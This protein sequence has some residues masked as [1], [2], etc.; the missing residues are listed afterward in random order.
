M[1]INLQVE[2]V[3][4]LLKEALVILTKRPEK[5]EE[6]GD[7]ISDDIIGTWLAMRWKT[8]NFTQEAYIDKMISDISDVLLYQDIVP[9]L[10]IFANKSLNEA[11]SL[12][13]NRVYVVRD[14][15]KSLMKSSYE[16]Y[17][18]NN[19]DE[20][21]EL[22]NEGM[23]IVKDLLDCEYKPARR[24]LVELVFAVPSLRKASDNEECH[25]RWHSNIVYTVF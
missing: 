16:F 8:A 15:I 19:F 20:Y 18:I 5:V 14:F 17:G 6:F 22:F 25:I 1:I 13:A 7:M 12:V 3:K 2:E 10:E 23:Q 11:M 9:E 4:V 24:E 21:M